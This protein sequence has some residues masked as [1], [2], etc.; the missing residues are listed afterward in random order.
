M[1]A[2]KMPSIFKFIS[3]S[4]RTAGQLSFPY[5][6]CRGEFVTGSQGLCILRSVVALA[7]YIQRHQYTSDVFMH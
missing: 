6:G 4:I 1:L 3:V 5:V 7:S 2:L